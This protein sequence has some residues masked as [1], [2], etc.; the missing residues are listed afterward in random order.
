MGEAATRKKKKIENEKARAAGEPIPHPEVEPKEFEPKVMIGTMESIS[1]AYV[2]NVAKLG[3]VP[4][5]VLIPDEDAHGPG[6]AQHIKIFGAIGD[7]KLQVAVLREVADK[8]ENSFES[9]NKEKI[10]EPN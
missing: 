8:I 1:A 3:Y 2:K 10:P 9:M 5:I 6:S 4:L 7:T